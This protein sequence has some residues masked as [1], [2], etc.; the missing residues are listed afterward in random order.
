[1]TKAR[2]G[3]I[4]AMEIHAAQRRDLAYAWAKFL[5]ALASMLNDTALRIDARNW[6]QEDED[7]WLRGP[8]DER[9]P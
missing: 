3:I 4:V 5:R 9:R 8:D 1:M 7:Y 2:P 6:A